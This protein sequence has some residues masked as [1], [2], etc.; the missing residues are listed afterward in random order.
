VEKKSSKVFFIGPEKENEDDILLIK[1][2][3][4]DGW[5]DN[6]TVIVNCSP[7]YS[8]RLVQL[9][10][11][12]LSYVNNNEL[13]ECINMEMPYPNT[14]Q[15][16]NPKSRQYEL[17]DRYLTE[18][19]TENLG[20]AKYLF[21]NT[22]CLKGKNFNKVKLLIRSKLEPDQYRFASTYVQSSSIFKPDYF[23]QE[24]D[25]EEKGGLLFWWE[26]TDNPNWNY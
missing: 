17:F 2:I 9:L 25:F 19:I 6:N 15:V 1:Q 22:G 3:K 10:N 26:N 7:D 13:F 14:N 20:S 21:I 5:F 24:F 16:W 12:S 18:W 4:D 11:H 23:T 8:S